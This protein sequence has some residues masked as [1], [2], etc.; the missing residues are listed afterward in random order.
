MKRIVVFLVCIQ[1]FIRLAAQPLS[2]TG[3]RSDSFPVVSFT[4]N[5]RNPDGLNEKKLQLTEDGKSLVFK[6]KEIN[7]SKSKPEGTDILI[8]FE[9][10][11]WPE[12][13][14]ERVYF[15]KL[16]D[17]TLAN[18]SGSKNNYYFS[19]FDWTDKK[20]KV[21]RFRDSSAYT[22]TNKLRADIDALQPEPVDGRPHRC[23]EIYQ[24]ISEGLSFLARKRGS[25]APLVL[26]LS[27]EFSNIYNDK[28]DDGE[29]I[30]QARRSDIPVYSVRY[31]LSSGKYNF[32]NLTRET[33]GKHL[34]ANANKID[35]TAEQ[36][37]E[38]LKGVAERSVGKEYSITTTVTGTADGLKH[39]L[40]LQIS[41]TDKI[42]LEYKAPGT[43]IY[44]L[45]KP[46]YLIIFI[47]IIL[48]LI[49]LLIW[50]ILRSKKRKALEKSNIAQKMEQARREAAEAVEAQEKRFKQ[51]LEQKEKEEKTKQEQLRTE[52]FYNEKQSRMKYLPRYPG[53]VDTSG[54][55][56]EI[57]SSLI[58]IGRDKTQNNIQIPD[59]SVS[60]MHAGIGFEHHKGYTSAEMTGRFYIWDEGSSNGTY[61][62][63]DLLP[64]PG[65]PGFGPRELR[66][67]DIVR[68]GAVVFTFNI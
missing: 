28:F 26:V 47:F 23:T 4:L 9:N 65:E 57:N 48:L 20:G 42:K 14:K 6:L 11:Y 51:T 19:T 64:K 39:N 44:L 5:D 12:Y 25:N 37:V 66:N 27:A 54:N 7:N 67:N 2:Q 63:N 59:P 31:P 61:I 22:S 32:V 18:F 41:G 40:E 49:G 50:F 10:T 15:K 45:S 38:L 68:F 55:R 3:G 30:V 60:R 62:N 21:L 46:V 56:F 24:A 53:L 52:A 17:K 29:V 16:L 43:I 1:P 8:L 34:Y 35:S 13:A 58:K 33:Y 36:L